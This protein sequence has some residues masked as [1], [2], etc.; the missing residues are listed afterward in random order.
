MAGRKPK[1]TAVKKLEGNPGKRK[2]NTKEPNPGKG[3]P[4]CPAWLLPEAKTEWIRLSEKLNQMGVLTE[5]DRSAFAA[6]E[7][8]AKLAAEDLK[9]DVQKAGKTVKQQI[10]STAPKKTGKYSKSWAV[11]KTRETS[12]SIQ[13][14]VHSKRYQL[15]HLLEFGHAKRGGGRTRAFPHIAPAE[16]AGIEQLT[17]DIERDLQK[18]G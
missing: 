16:Q 1:P 9:K 5:I 10:E 18:G 17:R 8:Y 7:E 15:T 4:D 12:D 3:M 2:L 6:M 14:V 11:K 13:I